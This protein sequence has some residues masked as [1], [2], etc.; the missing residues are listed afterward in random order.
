MTLTQAYHF[1][2]K[3]LIDEA[4]ASCRNVLA[5]NPENCDALHLL[6][7]VEARKNNAETALDLIGR[8]IAIRGNDPRFHLNRSLVLQQVNCL[9]EALASCDAALKHDPN[10]VR[11]LNNRGVILHRLGLNAEAIASYDRA[12]SI[13]P[14]FAAGHNNRGLTLQAMGLPDD[15]LASYASAIRCDSRYAE[16]LLNRGALLHAAGHTADALTDYDAAILLQPQLAEAHNNRGVALRHLNRFPEALAS[17]D[18]AIAAK[19]DYAQALNSRGFILHKLGRFPEAI[20]SY[21]RALAIAPDFTEALNNL[22][23]TLHRVNRFEDALCVYDRAL[24][25]DPASGAALCNRGQVLLVRGEIPEAIECL[26]RASEVADDASIHSA[27]IFGLNF[28][29]SVSATAKQLERST[30]WR[31]HGL[32]L[33]GSIAAHANQPDPDRRLRVG[34]VSGYFRRHASAYGFG[35]VLMN[36][37]H[38]LF[39]VVCYSDTVINDDL[40]AALREKADLWRDTCAV[41]DEKLAELIRGDRIDILVDLVGHM[42]GNRLLAFARKPAPVQ[43]TG[44]G[45]PTGTGMPVMDY[46]LAD[47]TLVPEWE[48]KLLAEGLIQLPNFLGYWMPDSLPSADRLPAQDRGYV[49]FGSFN[50]L[51]KLSG[52]ILLTWA[53]L[54]KKV[55]RARLVL[56]DRAFENA[57][58][59]GRVQSFFA[60]EGVAPNRL[61]LVS[62]SDRAAHFAM[63]GQIDIALDPFPHSGGMTTLDALWMGVPVVTSWGQTIASRL[64]ATS[65][66]ALGLN[67]FVARDLSEYV[68]VAVAKASNLESLGELRPQLQR[69]VAGSEFGDGL[70]YCRAVEQN[71]RA[72]WRQ[73]CRAQAIG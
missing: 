4:A 31:R 29:P 70:R 61:E 73:W 43:M 5:S 17:F 32:P 64:A 63:Y 11:A 16:A 56:K 23:V 62:E 68:D 12:L 50:R 36:H 10:Y 41:P 71:Y 52:T 58:Q 49:T 19:P 45:E 47:G 54:L 48:E 38:S 6:A 2:Q 53:R 14:Q 39:D 46:L 57:A 27:L 67:S 35:G 21:Q 60:D 55:E 30:W 66:S 28:D 24:T 72:V 42:A 13:D 9:D 40:T 18:A 15:A 37:D 7:I 22:G 8:A 59:R 44:W 26:R 34:Y 69:L 65:L 1:Y 33:A 20:E 51:E 3:G 25:I